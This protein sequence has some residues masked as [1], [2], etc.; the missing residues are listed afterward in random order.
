MWAP[1]WHSEVDRLYDYSSRVGRVEVK[2]CIGGNRIHKFSHKQLYSTSQEPVHVVSILLQ[3]EEE[4]AGLTLQQLI[5]ECRA[6]LRTSPY[7]VK[8]ERAIRRAG[9]QE[10]TEC[11]PIFNEQNAARSIQWFHARDIPHFSE[12]EPDN[13]SGTNYS[14]NLGAAQPLSVTDILDLC[15]CWKDSV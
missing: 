4:S 12:P 13:V 7:L 1:F 5:E 15:T 3:K 6:A 8:L 2:T 10:P 11:G 14:A 9:M